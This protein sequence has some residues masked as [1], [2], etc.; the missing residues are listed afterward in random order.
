[1]NTDQKAA[2]GKRLINPDAREDIVRYINLKLAAM[3]LPYYEDEGKEFLNIANDL[4]QSHQEMKRLLHDHLCPADLRIQN[5]INKEFA[6][7]IDIE[8]VQLPRKTFILDRYG[9]ARELSL[10]VNGDDFKSDLVESYRIQQGV[11]HNP[12]HDRRT[13][14]GAFHVAEGGLP[15]AADKKSSP[16]AAFA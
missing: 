11:L 3:G 5:F 7:V 16:K 4:I 9:L 14:K 1:M 13:T 8:T 6:D 2:M 10:P 12:L 15:I